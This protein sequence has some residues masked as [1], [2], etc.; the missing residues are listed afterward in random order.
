MTRVFGAGSPEWI[1]GRNSQ[2]APAG[3]KERNLAQTDFVGYAIHCANTSTSICN[4]NP[5]AKPDPLPDEAQP[6]GGGTN[7]YQNY[8]ALFGP[9]YVNPAINHGSGCIKDMGGVKNITDQFDQCGFPGFDGLFPRNTLAEVAT[10]QEAGIPVTFGYLSDAHDAHGLAG[11]IHHAYGPGEQ[12]YVDQLKAYDQSFAQF[13]ARLQTDGITNDN[14]LFVITVEEGDHVASSKPD[15][16]TC[17]GVT[18]GKA[19]TYANV[20]EAQ[21]DLKRLVA[22]YNASHGTSATTNFSVHSDM[23]PNV[24]INGNPA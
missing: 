1:E 16:P 7:G 23:A 5:N 18:P 9:K 20:S 22:T 10:M 3:T 14:T 4:G 6:G 13:F 21:G 15:D 19:C 8:K 12:G 24:Y 11:E 2:I 17:D